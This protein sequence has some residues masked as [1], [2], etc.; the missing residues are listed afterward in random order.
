MVSTQVPR[1]VRC[2]DVLEER[3]IGL[4]TP[5][6]PAGR[7]IEA[8]REICAHVGDGEVVLFCGRADAEEYKGCEREEVAH[9]S[10]P[11]GIRQ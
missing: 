1:R 10:V 7:G 6:A 11:K 8:T 9:T 4:R 2:A 5:D 3:E